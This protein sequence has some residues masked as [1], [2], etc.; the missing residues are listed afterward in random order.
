MQN[1]GDRRYRAEKGRM[2]IKDAKW[3]EGASF[4]YWA[5][6]GEEGHYEC[7]GDNIETNSS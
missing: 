7:A 4:G 3:G 2:P 6:N 5:E 1:G